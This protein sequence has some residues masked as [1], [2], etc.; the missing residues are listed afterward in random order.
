MKLKKLALNAIAMDHSEMKRIKAGYYA[1]YECYHNIDG[2]PNGDELHF[3]STNA[4]NS[5]MSSNGEIGE[6]MIAE[7]G[8]GGMICGCIPF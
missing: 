5:C 4:G 1:E 8:G 2:F 3:C 6:C 7:T